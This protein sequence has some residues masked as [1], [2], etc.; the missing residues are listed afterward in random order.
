LSTATDL[1][2]K[3]VREFGLSAKLGPVGYPD[4]GSVFLGG[5]GSGF[6][7]R[8]FAEST[9][10][11]IDSEV[12]RLLREAEHTA[13]ETIRTHQAQLDE[14]VELLLLHET[15][16]GAEVYRIVGRPVPSN[17]QDQIA[18]APRAAAH[19]IA[20]GATLVDTPP[21]DQD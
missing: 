12:A 14:L 17:R 6:S 4:G 8:P 9:Q 21:A 16:D 3:M 15:V 10:A 11:V 18:I 20:S 5:G 2:T 13:I 19:S 1:A 7:S